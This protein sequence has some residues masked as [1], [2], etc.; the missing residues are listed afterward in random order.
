MTSP[1][2]RG[3]EGKV[4]PEAAQLI[5]QDEIAGRLA[6]LFDLI[7]STI[8]HGN[9]W[10]RVVD[11]TEIPKRVVFEAHSY[12]LF[13]DGTATIFTEPNGPQV[14]T[15]SSIV[16]GVDQG[17]QDY[18]ALGSRRTVEFWIACAEG[19]TARVRIRGTV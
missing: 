13:N 6:D 18:V 15:D 5:T 14:I 10:T 11:V 16:A 4:T 17:D 12:T 19:E 8:S 9:A 2:R 1:R 3:I 7:E